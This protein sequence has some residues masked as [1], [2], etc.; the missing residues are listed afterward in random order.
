MPSLLQTF[1]SLTTVANQADLVGGTTFKPSITVGNP[2]LRPESADNVNFGLS[3]IPQEGPLE[4]LSVDLDWYDYEYTD[5]ITRQSSSTL[6]AEDNAAISAYVAANPGTSLA[7]ASRLAARNFNQIIRNSS[8]ILLRILPNFA[9]ANSADISGL[10]A[11]IAY[12]FDN[13]WGNWRIGLQ[14]AWIETFDVEVPNSGGG[15]TVFDGVGSY[16]STNPVARPLPEFKINGTLSWSKDNHRV[17]AL[18]RWVDEIESDVPAGT[19]GFFA[20]TARLAGNHSV[21]N[22]LADTVIEDM[23]TVDLQY[24][25]SFGETSFLSDASLA[26]FKFS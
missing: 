5:I 22:D 24:N 18:V 12:R 10:D 20:A 4:G 15:V 26:V 23:T 21:A 3:W 1:G 16:N 2:N 19:R 13:D 17:F 8:G 7:D 11:N 6:L 9:N 14:A 25:Y